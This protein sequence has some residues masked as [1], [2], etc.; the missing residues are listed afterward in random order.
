[1]YLVAAEALWQIDDIFEN[2]KNIQTASPY[3]TWLGV[4]V[5]VTHDLFYTNDND[6]YD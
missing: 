2:I 6:V 4:L 1:M 5:Q 3:H